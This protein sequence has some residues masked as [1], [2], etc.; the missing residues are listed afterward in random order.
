MASTAWKNCWDAFFL[1]IVRVRCTMC[2]Q[3][4]ELFTALTI[5]ESETAQAY[6]LLWLRK[7]RLTTE[8]LP[9]TFLL[10][11]F[12]PCVCYFLGFRYTIPHFR[13]YKMPAHLPICYLA[14]KLASHRVVGNRPSIFPFPSRTTSAREHT[15]TH[16]RAHTNAHARTFNYKLCLFS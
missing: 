9:S 8:T 14:N 6:F 5:K 2:R 7:E 3:N 16:T 10:P 12:V 15:C 4:L 1:Q 13:P 11:E